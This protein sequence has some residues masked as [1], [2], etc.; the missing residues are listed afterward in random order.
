MSLERRGPVAPASPEIGLPL[1]P[2]PGLRLSVCYRNPLECNR[3]D[4]F[5][6]M[7]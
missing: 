4:D 5:R 3:N 2:Q 1:R 7:R 6:R